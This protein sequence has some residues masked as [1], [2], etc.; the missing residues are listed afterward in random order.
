MAAKTTLKLSVPPQQLGALSFCAGPGDE[1]E[2][3]LAD[4]PMANVDE[5][6]KRLY[7]AIVEV[8]QLQ[9]TLEQRYAMVELLRAPIHYTCIGLARRFLNQPVIVNE[10][11]RRFAN[12]CQV[13]QNQLAVGYK[14]LVVQAIQERVAFGPEVKVDE[15]GA[16]VPIAIYRAI[17]ELTMTLLRSCQLYTD[18]NPKVWLE[19]NQLMLLS[20]RKQLDTLRLD[21]HADDEHH[22]PFT[23]RDAYLRAALLA[24]VSPNKLRQRQLSALYD[25]LAQWVQYAEFL[26]GVQ[27]TNFIVDLTLDEPPVYGPAFNAPAHENCRTVVTDILVA[28]IEQS[29]ERFGQETDDEPTGEPLMVSG[30]SRELL[31]HACNSWGRRTQRAY[32]RLPSNGKLQ[33]CIGM[34][35]SHYHLA[36][37]KDFESLL[38]KGQVFQAIAR[39]RFMDRSDV[40]DP[41]RG[42]SDVWSAA[43]DSGSGGAR[44]P[45]N[46]DLDV[47]ELLPE[48]V[49]EPERAPQIENPLY[50]VHEANMV[51]TSPGGYCV[52]W[53]EDPPSGL[54]TGELLSIRE[55]GDQRWSLAVVRWMRHVPNN[56]TLMGMQLVAPIA[57]PVGARQTNRKDGDQQ[58]LRALLLPA[59]KVLRQPAMLVLPRVPFSEG[60]RLLINQSGTEV[61]AHLTR[62]IAQ[63]DAFSQ[64]EFRLLDTAMNE[65]TKPAKPG[66][67]FDHLFK[68]TGD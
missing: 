23:I 16:I 21:D 50:P 53:A 31:A 41:V 67:N 49:A 56:G 55:H 12:Q 20:E 44:M 65:Q 33:V 22:G 4:L 61:K 60:Q 57:L 40:Y 28:R 59:M 42:Q 46:P 25:A 43:F 35:A 5:V 15:P 13:L 7:R 37:G 6:A 2:Q 32:A 47:A 26:N 27:D 36:E 66:D 48:R 52:R 63:T 8:C 24:T 3:W 19:L 68:D 39:N 18:P 38:K 14:V 58:Y 11:V 51:D 1:F 17:G 45:E 62:L 10:T 54:Q 9:C 34:S 64:F 29:I 30:L